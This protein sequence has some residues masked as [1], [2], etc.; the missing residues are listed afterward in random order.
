MRLPAVIRRTV[1]G[2]SRYQRFNL[3]DGLPRAQHDLPTAGYQ[4][5]QF[6]RTRCRHVQL[7]AAYM[8]MLWVFGTFSWPG[9][10]GISMAVNPWRSLSYGVRCFVIGVGNIWLISYLATLSDPQ[11][12]RKLAL[13]QLSATCALTF[14]WDCSSW[15]WA[16]YRPRPSLIVPLVVVRIHVIGLSAAMLSLPPMPYVVL[17]TCTHVGLLSSAYRLGGGEPIA[18]VLT[19]LSNFAV[20]TANYVWACRDSR[21]QHETVDR[22]DKLRLRVEQLLCEKDRL[23]YDRQLADHRLSRHESASPTAA[24]TG[25]EDEGAHDCSTAAASRFGADGDAFDPSL[26]AAQVTSASSPSAEGG[27]DTSVTSSSDLLLEAVSCGVT[28]LQLQ[29]SPHGKDGCDSSDATDAMSRRA[30]GNAATPHELSLS[31]MATAALS[32]PVRAT[33]SP[34]FRAALFPA[35]P[36]PSPH[37]RAARGA[38]FWTAAPQRASARRMAPLVSSATVARPARRPEIWDSGRGAPAPPPGDAAEPSAAGE[39]MAEP[40]H[41]EGAADATAHK[42]PAAATGTLACARAGDFTTAPPT[43]PDG[44]SD[45]GATHEPPAAQSGSAAGDEVQDAGGEDADGSGAVGESAVGRSGVAPTGEAA[46]A[47]ATPSPDC[48]LSAWSEA[49]DS[50]DGGGEG[51]EPVSDDESASQL[52]RSAKRRLQR[53]AEKQRLRA[54]LQTSQLRAGAQATA[55]QPAAQPA[56]SSSDLGV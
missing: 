40:G 56:A 19:L 30:E 31:G 21:L 6:T 51:A 46:A 9:T 5:A 8:L 20:A 53:K 25:Q 34:A 44:A 47:C 4:E 38:P 52:T 10:D 1:A 39:P 26:G 49:A 14:L 15:R 54:R 11:W 45:D 23:E 36:A 3:H 37:S 55:A 35:E 43:S 22:E 50:C 28:Q 32:Q 41:G 33:S 48:D 2:I 13:L 12:A 42:P 7:I 17:N 16:E 24:G 27:T 18:T 29:A